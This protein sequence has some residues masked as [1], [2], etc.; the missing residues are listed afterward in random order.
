MSQ[1]LRV[2]ILPGSSRTGSFNLQLARLAESLLR[3]QGAEPLVRDLRALALPLYDGDLEASEG[4]PQG[5]HTLVA[6]IAAHDALLVVSPEYNAFPPPLLINAIDWA[7]RLPEHKAAMGG[8]PTALLSA[9]PGA[10][11]GIRS[12][13]S[14]RNFL[15]LNPGLLVLPQ[16]F[17][18]NQAG[19]AFDGQGSLREATRQQ[20]LQDVLAALL[21]HAAA[22]RTV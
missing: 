15:A 10:F 22:L 6:E 20:A 13:L 2:L 18:L 1:P 14:L 16:Q 19:Q 4:V 11:G 5:A 17:A 8:K 3:E 9:S 12:L 21:R 7:S